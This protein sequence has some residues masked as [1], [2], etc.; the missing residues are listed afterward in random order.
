MF[1]NS[2]FTQK[3]A[4]FKKIP[5]LVEKHQQSN[6]QPRFNPLAIE[7]PLAWE[8]GWEI[9]RFKR[10]RVG[11]R[12]RFVQDNMNR[13]EMFSPL[14]HILLNSILSTI[15]GVLCFVLLLFVARVAGITE[16]FDPLLRHINHIPSIAYPVFL[17]LPLIITFVI[18]Q[19]NAKKLQIMFDNVAG[20][21]H[22]SSNTSSYLGRTSAG[23]STIR[24]KQ[25]HALQ[26][27]QKR[28]HQRSRTRTI[29]Q[30]NLVLQN[31]DRLHLS[32]Y[33]S[34]SSMRRSAKV[35]ADF[36]NVVLWDA[37]ESWTMPSPIR[38]EKDIPDVDTAVFKDA[39]ASTIA[40]TPIIHKWRVSVP[41]KKALRKEE[42]RLIFRAPLSA[43]PPAIVS[44]GCLTI[45]LLIC[46][47][48]ICILSLFLIPPLAATI[49]LGFDYLSNLYV[50]YSYVLGPYAS[51]QLIAIL[52]L[53]LYIMWA[54]YLLKS[55]LTFD[56]TSGLFWKGRIRPRIVPL[57]SAA[58]DPLIKHVS[59][60]EIYAVQ[61]LSHG[62][63]GTFQLN[64]VLRDSTRLYVKDYSSLIGASHILSNLEA[65]A[66]M[67]TEAQSVAGF[68]NVPLWDS[69]SAEYENG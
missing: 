4:M 25:I 68:L 30:I 40:W 43:I 63:A 6:H 27:L 35:L 2:R 52:F 31:G 41:I 1:H 64:L 49:F 59:L 33:N 29:H 24:L 10:Q 12:P 23:K 15:M 5:T 16:V 22:I 13:I 39:I 36:L 17:L 28:V 46:M 44:V 55:P 62:N 38:S 14:A 37:T 11:Y 61:L 67:N 18:N 42:N 50:D 32:D 26:L 19:N 3:A 7:D 65:R 9:I 20:L 69:S 51:P 54:T 8:T 58:I 56:R 53:G 60:A 34:I 66:V 45:V 21:C 57:F 48:F 47:I